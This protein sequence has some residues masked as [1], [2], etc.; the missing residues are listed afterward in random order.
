PVIHKPEDASNIA[1]AIRRVLR[2]TRKV[3]RGLGTIRQELNI[4][5]AKGSLTEIKGVQE[6]E[7]VSKVVELEVKRQLTL[8][9]TRDE[10][11]KRGVHAQDLEDHIIDVNEILKS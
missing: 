1:L 10:L 6:L 4:S 8:L 7:L 2:A 3:K 9:E 11:H 5:I